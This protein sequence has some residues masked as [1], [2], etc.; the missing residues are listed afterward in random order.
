MDKAIGYLMTHDSGFAPNP[1]HGHL[2]LATCKPK[3]RSASVVG[4]WVAGF[5]SKQLVER[6]LKDGLQI[7]HLGLV[8]LM[9]VGEV[10]PLDQYFRDPR[11]KAKRPTTNRG[12]QVERCGDNIYFR[13]KDGEF[14][15]RRNNNHGE[16]FTTHDTGGKN[17][18]IAS[19]FYYFGRRCFVPDGGWVKLLG[20]NLSTGRTFACPSGFVERVLDHFAA[21][22][23][24]AGMSGYPCDWNLDAEDMRSTGSPCYPAGSKSR[25]ISARR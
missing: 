21:K 9:R 20:S 18:L 23:V 1:F 24:K 19:E 14:H 16:N 10:M 22:R 4:D 17:A 7:P 12:G 15:Q 5:A 8:Y 3:V 2:T 11:F 25:P 13:R 6:S